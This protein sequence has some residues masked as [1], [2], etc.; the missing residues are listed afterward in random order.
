MSQFD[1]IDKNILKALSQNARIAYSTLA[2]DLGISNTMV[3]Q[4]V[5]KL[6]LTGVI[7]QPTYQFNPEVLGFTT[8]AFTWV[9]ISNPKYIDTVVGKLKKVP[10]IIECSNVTGK[11]ALMLKIIAKD[12]NHLREVIYK[13]IHPLPGVS[14]TDTIISFETSFQK[15]I[16]I[17]AI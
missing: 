2:K 7:S 12:N 3:H 4:R 10:E 14:N 6:K 1:A 11:Y 9:E 5:N 17:D 8:E 15:N 13:K 16:D